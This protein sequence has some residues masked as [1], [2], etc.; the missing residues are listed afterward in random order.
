MQMD[1]ALPYELRRYIEQEHRSI[2]DGNQ[3]DHRPTS[4]RELDSS[5]EACTRYYNRGV[6][7]MKEIGDKDLSACLRMY[8]TRHDYRAYDLV[9]YRILGVWV[10]VPRYVTLIEEMR[11]LRTAL[12]N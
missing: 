9:L 12:L 6:E 5:T 3:A 7:L 2:C 8:N 11:A 1:Q 4:Q 10:I